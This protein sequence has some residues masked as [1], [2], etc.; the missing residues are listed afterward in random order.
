MTILGVVKERSRFGRIG[1]KDSEYPPA[2]YMA[3]ILNQQDNLRSELFEWS[4]RLTFEVPSTAFDQ[5]LK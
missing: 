1:S 4:T 2:T 5:K 3:A